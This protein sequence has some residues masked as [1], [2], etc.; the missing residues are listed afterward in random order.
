L[1]FDTKQ[2]YEEQPISVEW[3][4]AIKG[5]RATGTLFYTFDNDTAQTGEI[6]VTGERVK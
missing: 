6:E 4:L 3:D 2:V 1:S 5:N